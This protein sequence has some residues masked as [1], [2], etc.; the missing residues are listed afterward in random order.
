MAR[1]D[2]SV[3]VDGARAL[4]IARL[5]FYL[6]PL[7]GQRRAVRLANYIA[8]RLARYRINGGAWRRFA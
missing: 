5:A 4:R 1:C 8:F 7:I 2:V 3:E 6:W